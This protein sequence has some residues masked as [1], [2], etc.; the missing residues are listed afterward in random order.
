MFSVYI[1]LIILTTFLGREETNGEILKSIM[2]IFLYRR[3]IE[4]LRNHTTDPADFINYLYQPEIDPNGE[5]IHHRED[6][7]HLLKRVCSSLRDG[8]IPGLD[9]RH[10][11]DALHDPS[12]GLTYEALTGKN[13]Q[14]VPDCERLI[15]CGVVDYLRRMGYDS[16]VKVIERLHN[17]HKAVD[18]R[19]LSE[20]QRSSYCMEMK[21][22]LLADWMPWFSYMPDYHTIN[23]NGYVE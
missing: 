23:V 6:H 4:D 15:G 19:G 16:D 10:L 20:T 12:T 3:K 22:W 18:G 21:K 14:S 13:K 9:L 8:Y 11:C 1:Y 7:N 5:R 2:A 17:W